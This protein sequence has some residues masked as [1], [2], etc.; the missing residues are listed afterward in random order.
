MSDKIRLVSVVRD[1]P[2]ETAMPTGRRTHSTITITK[3]IDKASPRFA[4]GAEHQ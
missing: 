3:E 4:H 1:T 2:M